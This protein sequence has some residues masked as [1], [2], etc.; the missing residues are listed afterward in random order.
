MSDYDPNYLDFEQPILEL[1]SKIKKIHDAK[2]A[3]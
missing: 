1:E 3:L 2:Y